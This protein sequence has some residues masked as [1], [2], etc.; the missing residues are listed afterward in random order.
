MLSLKNKPLLIGIAGRSGSGKTYIL[1]LLQEALLPGTVS[2]ISQDDYYR[3]I[4][5]QQRDENGEVNF[6]LPSAIDQELFIGNIQ[7]LLAGKAIQKNSYT[8]NN[9]QAHS[10]PLT[11]EPAPCIIVEGLFI[12]HYTALARLIDVKLFIDCKESIALK[13]RIQ[14]DAEERGYDNTAVRYQWKNHVQPAYLA[15]LQPYQN[16]ADYVLLNNGNVLTLDPIIEHIRS[17]K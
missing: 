13:R 3:S 1:R 7:Q 16:S 10:I 8:F 11:I 5:Q 15:Y 14:R 2:I 4:E 17:F 12:Y 6:D 9:P